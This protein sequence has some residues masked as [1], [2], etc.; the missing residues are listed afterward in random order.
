MASSSR[1]LNGSKTRGS[2]SRPVG[3]ESISGLEFDEQRQGINI[4]SLFDQTT[5]EQ[6]ERTEDEVC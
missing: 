2:T 6:N 1:V 5:A 3:V 4:R